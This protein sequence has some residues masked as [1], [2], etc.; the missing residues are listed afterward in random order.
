MGQLQS[1]TGKPLPRATSS[2]IGPIAQTHH[3]RVLGL[4]RYKLPQRRHVSRLG[5]WGW[6]WGVQD[7]VVTGDEVG[8]GLIGHRELLHGAR[9][10]QLPR[11]G[12]GAGKCSSG[13]DLRLW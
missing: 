1:V 2:S 11:E 12:A 9:L 3:T 4:Q 7:V 13:P 8:V 5:V 10:D 6:R